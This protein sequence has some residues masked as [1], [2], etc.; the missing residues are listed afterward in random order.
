[1]KRRVAA[2]TVLAFAGALVAGILGA[3][4]SSIPFPH[5]AH[6]RLFPVCDGCHAG[7]ATGD[8]EAAYP[9]PADCAMCHDGVSLDAVAWDAPATRSGNIRFSHPAHV[10]ALSRSPGDSMATCQACHASPGAARRMDVG[11]PRPELCISCHAHSAESHLDSAAAC[12]TCHLPLAEAQ[13]IPVGRVADFPRP[14]WHD[15]GD[16]L[17]GHGRPA[18]S[19]PASCATCHARETCERCHANAERLPAI[20]ELGRDSRVAELES[21]RSAF[22]PTPAS[23]RAVSWRLVHGDSARRDAATCA[24]CHTRPSCTSCHMGGAGVANAAVS[25][26]PNPGRAG[27]RGVV[28]DRGRSGVHPASFARS[29]GIAASTGQMECAQCH[30]Q[31]S[32][33][34]CHAGQESRAFHVANFV[35]RHAADVFAGTSSCQSC[36]STEVFCRDCHLKSGVASGTGMNAA[37]HTGQP[38]WILSHGQAARMGM[39]SCASC[40]RQSDCVR[41]HSAL[42]GWGVSP[43]GPGFPADRLAARSATTCAA[44]HAGTPGRSR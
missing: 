15:T 27:V 21:T 33:A 20:R 42:G 1:M 8:M 7:I 17:S 24:N 11:A 31:Q 35:E 44:C 23:H 34:G 39:Q 43:H 14:E 5:A 41:C 3:F 9:R 6:D 40:H 19:R 13:A 37:F 22:H 26:L 29:H 10:S 18:A 32:C 16:F 30:S 38:M 4:E 36:H 25:S 28:V 12:G 2:V